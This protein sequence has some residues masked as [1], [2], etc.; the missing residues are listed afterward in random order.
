[1]L[2][3]MAILSAVLRLFRRGATEAGIDL[4]V[5]LASY[6]VIFGLLWILHKAFRWGIRHIGSATADLAQAGV[7]G[8]VLGGIIWGGSSCA[9]FVGLDAILSRD[10]FS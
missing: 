7:A 4:V 2:I 8:A 5:Q 10:G 1:M 3:G 9:F 6:L